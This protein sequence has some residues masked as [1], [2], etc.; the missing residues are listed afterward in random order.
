MVPDISVE[1]RTRIAPF[2]V[3]R[4]GRQTLGT[5]HEGDSSS[6]LFVFQDY[7][8]LTIEDATCTVITRTAQRFHFTTQIYNMSGELFTLVLFS[9][10]GLEE[11]L[12]KFLFAGVS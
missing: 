4:L 8:Y 3:S 5:P 12:P 7:E 11:Q 2:T 10:L 6:Y 9:G 1:D